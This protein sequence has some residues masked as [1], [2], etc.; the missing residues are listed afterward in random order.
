MKI[1]N[2]HGRDIVIQHIF[3]LSDLQVGQKWAAGDG[4]DNVVIIVELNQDMVVYSHLNL[5]ND[6]KNEYTKD[7]FSF[8]CRYC[9]VLGT[10][11][12]SG[13]RYLMQI[14]KTIMEE[15]TADLDREIN[16]ELELYNDDTV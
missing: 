5:K 4:T 13:P 15:Y 10:D 2:E 3:A 8:Q 7:W 11:P 1:I 9:Y 6:L 16:M 12:D 14:E